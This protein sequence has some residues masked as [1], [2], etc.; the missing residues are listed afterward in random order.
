M[1]RRIATGGVLVCALS[2][3]APTIGSLPTVPQSFVAEPP[4]PNLGMFEA[5]GDVGATGIAGSARYDTATNAY[6]VT[7][8][9][10]NIWGTTDAF[11]YVWTKWAGDL[12]AAAAVAW[13]SAGLDPH[14]K[15]GVMV[16]KNLTPGSPYADIMLHGD[17]LVALQYREAQDGPTREIQ[18][19]VR[20]ATRLRLEVE[21][22]YVFF[23]VAPPGGIVFPVGGTVRHGGGNFRLP[24]KGQ[25]YVGLAV[26]AHNNAVA[27]TATFT[28]ATLSRPK[29]AHVP[30]TGY[31]AAV[32][33]T[34]EIMDVGDAES[35]R[36]VRHFVGKIEAPNWSRD[37]GSLIYNSDGLIY[38]IPVVGGEPTVI[39]TGPQRKNNN[40][41]GLSFDGKWLAISD[42]SQTDDHS[43][44]YVL[45]AAGSDKPKLV[46]SHPKA[47]SYWHG[48]SPD[49]R[50]IV[51]TASRPSTGD[52]DIYVKRVSGGAET[53]LTT[54]KG[55][56]DGPEY[57]PDGKWIYFNS[58][59]D[60][61]MQIWRMRPDG[62]GQEQVTTDPSLRDWFP[63]FSPDGKWIVFISF[64]T[65]VDVGDHPPNRDV[66]LRIMPADSS[67]PPRVLTKLFGGQGTIN[68][69]SWSPDSKQIAFVSYRLVR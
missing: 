33:S 63:H 60:G 23:S 4:G 52:Y 40:D 67:A 44:I 47:A 30:D 3:C 26:S 11:H 14:R 56:D 17:G 45:P 5:N 10:E 61:A 66:M 43:R 36:V 29:L 21:G 13:P 50:T 37:G 18:S 27:E 2:G 55:L 12:H 8:G 59:R 31:P 19:N 64:G 58:A 51:Y 41:H 24:F 54:A 22:D 28:N 69:P 16:R 9:G 46:A 68:V 62:S 39:P 48:W 25:Y 34:L 57:S 65:D 32:E 7:G 15:A 1:I 20:G 53:R 38:R 6:T 35:R 42:Q 49:G